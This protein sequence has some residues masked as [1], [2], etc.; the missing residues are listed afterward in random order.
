MTDD[1]ELE[2]ADISVVLEL[3]DR[4]AELTE[5]M[6]AEVAVTWRGIIGSVKSK[7]AEVFGLIDTRLLQ[8]LDGQPIQVDGTVYM[9]DVPT[10]YR[11]RQDEIASAVVR[12]ASYDDEGEL[13]DT[14]AAVEIAVRIM[15]DLYVS[16]SVDPKVGGL[17]HLGLKKAQV[18]KFENQAP[19]VKVVTTGAPD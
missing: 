17:N 12:K 18:G 5:D 9:K 2:Y 16:P 8:L 13:R 3:L 14:R 7:A 6:P 4:L 15:R 11:A 1:F 19:A 10:K